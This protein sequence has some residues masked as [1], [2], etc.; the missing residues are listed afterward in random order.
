MQADL[1]VLTHFVVEGGGLPVLCEEDHADRLVEVVELEAR[2]ADAGHDGGIG[3]DV[4]GDVELAGAE[5]E[6][7]VG[8]CA[9]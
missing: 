2:A 7:C 4:C 9:G 5:D 1:H 6:V 3:D 8:C